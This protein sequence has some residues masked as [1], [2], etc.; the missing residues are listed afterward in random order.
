MRL[1]IILVASL[2]SIYAV[3]VGRTCS[4]ESKCDPGFTCMEVAFM[5]NKANMCVAPAGHACKT[6]L[7]CV[8]NLC[9]NKVCQACKTDAECTKNT[10][11]DNG[12]CSRRFDKGHKCEHSSQCSK[13]VF[14][15]ECSNGVCVEAGKLGLGEVCS[16]TECKQG[17]YCDLTTKKCLEI[18]SSD[19]CSNDAQCSTG[20][21][22][23][24]G[25][26]CSHGG[27]SN[28]RDAYGI[29]T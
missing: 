6:S 16:S 3:G 13:I 4:N 5:T 22:C 17:L 11:C 10:Y 14:N 23:W 9:V 29:C 27:V 12:R 26:C 28:C 15:L 20:A 1:V 25:R 8:S 21:I 18:D 2:S 19:S 24:C 7:A